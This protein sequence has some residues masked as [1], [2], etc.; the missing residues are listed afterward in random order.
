MVLTWWA[1]TSLRNCE[2]VRLSVG[3]LEVC[4]F[5]STSHNKTE[6]PIATTH[7]QCRHAGGGGGAVGLGR[8]P[9]GGG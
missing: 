2:Y 1:S 7:S 4:M 6:L 3:T 8:S 9:G 5:G